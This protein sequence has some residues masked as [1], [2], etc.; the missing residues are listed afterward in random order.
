MKT[1]QH[2]LKKEDGFND[3]STYLQLINFQIMFRMELFVLLLVV[4]I[5]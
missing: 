1:K 3:F 4:K 2:Y 5:F